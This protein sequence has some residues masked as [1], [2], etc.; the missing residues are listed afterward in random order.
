M[1]KLKSTNTNLK[2]E[3]AKKYQSTSSKTSATTKIAALNYIIKHLSAYSKTLKHLNLWPLNSINL[4]RSK[5]TK[6]KLILITSTSIGLISSL[7]L[8]K[9]QPNTAS[10]FK[11]K[12]AKHLNDPTLVHAIQ[13]NKLF[14]EAHNDI[15]L[16]LENK[17]AKYLE[18]KNIENLISLPRYQNAIMFI[19]YANLYPNKRNYQRVL[20]ELSKLSEY[21]TH[22]AASSNINQLE[23]LIRS[24]IIQN[25]DIKPPKEPLSKAKSNINPFLNDGLAGKKNIFFCYETFCLSFFKQRS[26][27]G[28]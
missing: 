14:Q 11:F 9:N 27:V 17:G 18:T 28:L 26:K 20:D 16:K 1:I 23:E 13:T 21:K 6:S 8:Y 24:K 12:L 19:K 4:K 2:N 3:N 22:S 5:L 7:I 10:L 25:F 15:K